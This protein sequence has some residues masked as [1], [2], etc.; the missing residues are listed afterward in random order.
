MSINIALSGSRTASAE[1]IT[2]SAGEGSDPIP[3]LCRKLI[4][5][6]Y[7]PATLGVV[8]RDGVVVFRMPRAIGWWAK[9]RISDRASGG[10][11]RDRY[12]D[13]RKVFPPPASAPVSGKTD[14]AAMV[15]PPEALSVC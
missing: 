7:D 1:G 15:T 4:R 2:H 3:G 9:W 12:T 6:G 14:T 11:R 10:F 8:L 13:P 5:K